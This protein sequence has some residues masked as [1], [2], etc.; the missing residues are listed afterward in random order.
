MIEIVGG[1]YRERCL[2]P[3]W[4]DLYG[5]GGRAAVALANLDNNVGLRT[6]ISESERENLQN[7]ADTFGFSYSSS[8]IPSTVSFDY[9]HCLSEPH[10]FPAIHQVRKEEPLRLEADIVLRFGFIEGDAIVTAKKAVYDPQNAFDPRPFSENGSVSESLAIVANTS[11]II[12]LTTGKFKWYE[13]ESLGKELLSLADA[14]VVVIKRGSLGALV[15]TRSEATHIPAYRTNKVWSIG[16]GDVFA[17]VFAHFWATVGMEPAEAA[18]IASRATA[19]YC[20]SRILPLPKDIEHQ[21][22]FSP[23]KPVTSFPVEDQLVYLAG[24]FFTMAER[25]IVSEARDRLRQQGFRV[26]SPLHDVGYGSAEQVAPQDL[27]GLIESDIVFAILDGLDSGTVYEVG[28]ARSIDK[29]VVVY[30]Q[31]ESL[32]DLK[33]MQGTGCEIV[34]DFVSSIYRVVWAAIEGVGK[35]K[36]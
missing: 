17:C 28:Y 9:Y 18:R 30:V 3:N 4:N 19:Y 14:E 26:F 6:Y 15:V 23:I 1:V 31:N 13:A 5:S 34:N 22:L 21:E 11:E 36:K 32:E 25:W 20:D 16:S 24:P 27:K 2:E 33:M 35:N 29:P 8:E 12:K 7:L 10:I